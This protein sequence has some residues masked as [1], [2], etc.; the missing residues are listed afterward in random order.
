MKKLP[1][2]D[3]I[4]WDVL[5]WSR[6]VKYWIPTLHT[7]PADAK[8]LAVG[9]RNGGLSL[10]LALMGFKVDCTDIKEP[11]EKAIS[12]HKKYRV[13]DKITYRQLDIVN[14]SPIPDTYDLV[15]AKSVI[16]GLKSNPSDAGTRNF[17][18]QQKAVSNIYAQLKKDGYFLSAENLTGNFLHKYA[19]LNKQKDKGWRYLHY[20]EIPVLFQPFKV[21]KTKT[22]GILPTS[23]RSGLLNETLFTFNKL[24]DFL[25]PQEKYIAFTTAQK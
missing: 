19:R 9:E 23:F 10:W 20:K 21:V 8:V 12:R 11:S 15:I 16:G 18:T 2:N 4:E 1:L 6:L 5:N 7:F 13:S 14:D 3:I 24:L 17:S 25:P 22:F